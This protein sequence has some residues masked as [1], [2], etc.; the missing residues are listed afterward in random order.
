MRLTKEDPVIMECTMPNGQ[1]LQLTYE[2]WQQAPAKWTG[3]IMAHR[4]KASIL[5]KVL[6]QTNR[7]EDDA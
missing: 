5:E 3:T 4:S 2:Q 7:E 6:Q 1:T